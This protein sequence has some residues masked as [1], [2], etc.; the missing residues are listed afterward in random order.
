MFLSQHDVIVN[1]LSYSRTKCTVSS[2]SSSIKLCLSS[3]Y[4]C[5]FSQVDVISYAVSAGGDVVRAFNVRYV[6]IALDDKAGD[7]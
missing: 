1:S 3:C 6:Y 7:L 5:C 2:L 4:L